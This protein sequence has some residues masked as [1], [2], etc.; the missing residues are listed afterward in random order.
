MIV[1]FIFYQ[2]AQL[3]FFPFVILYLALR[4][5][6]GKTVFG[7]ILH[8]FGFVPKADPTRPVFW[9]HAVSVGEVL[10]IQTLIEKVKQEIPYAFCYL[11][12]ITPTG[13]QMAEQ[14]LA[15]DQVSFLPFDFLLPMLLAYHRIRPRAL[16]IVEADLWPNLIMLAHYKKIPTYLVNARM[17]KKSQN[18]Y[19]RLKRFLVPLL[20][21][22]DKIYA[23]SDYDVKMFKN[24]G[25][26]PNKLSVLG[27]IKAA[28]VF[29]KWKHVQKVSSQNTTSLLV[30]CLHP[31]ELDIYLNLF[32]KL[33]PIYPDI[34]L[35]LAPRHFHWKEKLI[36]KTQETGFS[37][38]V[39]DETNKPTQS[40]DILLVCKL[41][42]LFNLYQQATLYFLGGTF[43]PIGGHNLLEPAVWG[44]ATIVGPHHQN[45]H[46][47]VQQLEKENGVIIANDE[48]M[49][50]ESVTKLLAN[51]EQRKQL[52]NN[53]KKWLEAEAKEVE[54]KLQELVEVLKK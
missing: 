13:K 12:C 23:Q 27:N 52:G 19:E 14:K 33:K 4:K 53:A 24:L 51:K 9:F 47:I 36:R 1:F 50:L 54:T 31:G 40:L 22:F 6:K 43:V 7:N 34:S 48:K 16:V 35:I 38:F 32:K 42:E 26:L 44:V 28:N 15:A 46:V 37:F 49:L 18:R 10:S 29:T 8:R 3:F 20:D 25:V 41:G 11:T 21:T 2:L 39:W 30:G 17:N 5:V 45:C